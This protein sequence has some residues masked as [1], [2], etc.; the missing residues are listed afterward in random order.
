ML[1]NPGE[2]VTIANEGD[3]EFSYRCTGQRYTLTP[4]QRRIVPWIHLQKLLGDPFLTNATR[5]R[6]RAREYARI[7]AMHGRDS[8]PAE[9]PKLVAYDSDGDRITTIVDDPDGAHALVARTDDLDAGALRAQLDQME[10]RMEQMTELL[11]VQD[12]ASAA[13]ASGSVATPDTPPDP[14]PSEPDT[15][16]IERIVP[17]ITPQT[18]PPDDSPPD[19]PA[20]KPKRTPVARRSR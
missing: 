12:R 6:E 17:N 16:V 5:E 9:W 2:Y 18:S 3:T 19:I 15:S 1:T 8:N 20:D 13:V 10:R 11:R 7:H 4:G 14:G